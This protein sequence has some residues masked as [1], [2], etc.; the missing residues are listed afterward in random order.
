MESAFGGRLKT[1]FQQR[2]DPLPTWATAPHCGAAIAD[3]PR[4]RS[5][6]ILIPIMVDKGVE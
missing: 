1:F 5:S 6:D 2:I 4:A 3:A